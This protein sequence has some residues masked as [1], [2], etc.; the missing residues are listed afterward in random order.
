MFAATFVPHVHLDDHPQE[1]IFAMQL[2]VSLPS[3]VETF[4]RDRQP[5]SERIEICY[6]DKRIVVHR[7]WT[8]IAD[9][10][11]PAEEDRVVSLD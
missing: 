8:P 1:D 6:A 11:E 4:V 5:D 3:T 7:G 2:K 10:C 9:G